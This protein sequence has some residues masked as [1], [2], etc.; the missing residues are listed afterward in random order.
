MSD[1]THI[2]VGSDLTERSQPALQRALQLKEQSAAALTLLHVIEPGLPL[3][4][5]EHRREEAMQ[6]LKDQLAAASRRELRRVWIEVVAGERFAAIVEQ[7]ETRGAD[8]IVL[9]DS[10]K[11]RWKDLFIGTTVERIVRFS[12]QPVLVVSRPGEEPYQRV[13]VA[14]DFSPGANRAL[15]V[16][17]AIAPEAGCQAVHAWQAPLA[18]QFS[19]KP[20]GNGIPPEESQHVRAAVERALAPAGL[21]P[22]ASLEVKIAEGNP[23]FAIRDALNSYR[24]DLLAMGTHARSTIGTALVGSVARDMLAEAPC[25]V[26]VARP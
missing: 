7:A 11:R 10:T 22:R 23:L 19:G 9:G 2:L 21:T 12:S 13:L 17:Q 26:L 1:I 16:V 14:Y 6:L 15:G 3:K 25:D 5:T 20:A 18:A 24:P 8:L 4:A